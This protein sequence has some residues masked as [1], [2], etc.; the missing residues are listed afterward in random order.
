MSFLLTLKRFQ[1]PPSVFIVNS[2]KVYACWDDNDDNN[3]NN[4]HDEDVKR[5]DFTINLFLF[6]K[7]EAEER[8]PGAKTEGQKPRKL[9]TQHT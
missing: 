5:T 4:S 8:N 1:P 7:L 9:K 6:F 3:D 2:E